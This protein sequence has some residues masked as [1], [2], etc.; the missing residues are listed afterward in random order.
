MLRSLHDLV[1]YAAS[2][3]DGEVGKVRDLYFDEVTWNVRYLIVETPAFLGRQVLIAPPAVEQVDGATRT[4][5]LALTRDRVANSPPIETDKPVS[6]QQEQRYFD[7]FGW[8]Y[9]W[10]TPGA[11]GVGMPAF[12]SVPPPAPAPP[13]GRQQEPEGDPTLRSMREVIGYG[14]Q[15]TDDQIG[16]VDDLVGDDTA[17]SI[18]YLVVDTRKWWFGK[19]VLIA[20]SWAERID[21]AG[22]M[23]HL[24]LPREVI[25]NSPEWDGRAPVNRRYEERLYDYYGRPVYWSA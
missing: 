10:G 21:W 24:G 18:R 16:Q 2:A 11:M 13:I 19:K 3:R 1:G 6:R 20:P 14:I 7:H 8:P 25:K 22:R 15:G 17:W 5:Q 12:S 4:V 9:Y 23:V